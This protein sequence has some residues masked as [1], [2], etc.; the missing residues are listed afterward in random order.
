MNDLIHVKNV[1]VGVITLKEITD[2]LAVEHNKA[3]KMVSKMSQEPSFGTIEKI[4]TVYNNKGQM[5]DTYLLN[6]KQAI[7]AAS[8]LDVAMLMKVINRL[9][10]L[11]NKN[12]LPVLPQTYIEA[13]EAL[14]KSE[15]EKLQL[16]KAIQEKDKVILAVADL[17]VKA[18]EVTIGDFAKNIAIPNMG[19]NNMYQWLKARG[20]V[21]MDRKPYQPYVERGYFVRRPSKNKINGEHRYTTYLTAKGTVWLAK[22]LKAE[23]EIEGGAA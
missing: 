1:E 15:K 6:K 17:N 20:F 11:E 4:A 22:I 19:Q 5:I 14:T 23:F 8:K 21:T 18:G 9:E 10:E 12:R 13:L 2:M 3:M 16:S 7:A